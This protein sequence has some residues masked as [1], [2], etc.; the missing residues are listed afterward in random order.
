MKRTMIL[1]GVLVVVFAALSTVLPLAAQQPPIKIGVLYGLG[2]PAAPYTKPAVMGHEMA[3]EEI[4]ARGGVLG[5]KLQLVVRDDQSKPDVGVR[6][7]RDLILKE[8][9]DFLTG[10]IHSGVALAVSEVAKEYKTVLLVSIAKTAALT[11]EKGHRYVFRSTSNTLIEGRAA[12]IL[13]AQKPFKRYAVMGPDYEY[14]HRIGDDFVAHM[15]KLKPDVQ[16]V[17]EAWPKFGERDF[18]PHINAV[19]QAKPEMVFSSI[20]GG[21][22]IAFVKQAKPFGFFEKVQYMAISQGDLDV[23]G[24]LGAESPEGMWVSSNY[25]FYYPDTPASREFAAKARTKVGDYPP[26]GVSYSYV[27]TH[28]LAEAMKKARTTDTEKVIDALE[29][30]T[31]D[32]PMGPITMR[33]ADHQANKG[34]YWGRLKKTPEYPFLIMGDIQYIAGE[35]T[36]RTLDELKA[37][38]GQK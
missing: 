33:A 26:S 27:S 24:P 9:V 25:N 30:L 23:L 14:G 13:M 19:I 32:T 8:K 16:I 5:R 4:N 35:Q 28:F 18:T 17:T 12:A 7:A 6:E 22:H 20:W 29:G 21:D 11:E 37:M 34:Q 15:K 2:G 38:R 3:V 31:I 36:M 10:I 1:S